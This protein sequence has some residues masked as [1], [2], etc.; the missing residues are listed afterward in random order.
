MVKLATKLVETLCPKQPFWR[1]AK[2]K[3]EAFPPPP[4]A[5]NVA[6]LFELPVENN[7]PRNFECKS[8]WGGGIV[9]LSKV[10]PFE[11]NR[12]VKLHLS[13][14][15]KT[16]L[17]T[18]WSGFAFT[19]RLLFIISTHKWVVSRNI[20]SIWIALSSFYLFIFY[21]EKFLTWIWRLP[22]SVYVKLKLSDVS[23]VL[24]PIV[25]ATFY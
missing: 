17:C 16:P 1:F 24:T 6:L 22:F 11:D 25:C 9:L 21:F 3:K 14:E 15:R 7:Q 10:T 4:P 18:T 12:V 20:L 19:C 5:C 13:V 8:G 2:L 23:S